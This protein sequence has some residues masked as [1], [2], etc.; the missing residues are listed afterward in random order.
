MLDTR[1]TYPKP[2]TI[3]DIVDRF[4]PD[5]GP[6]EC[7]YKEFHRDPELS[8]L[9]KNISETTA[10]H[11]ELLGYV[12][13]RGI[14]GYGVVG[15]LDNGPGR[16]VLLRSELD[17]LPLFEKTGLPYASVKRMTDT[18]G[19]TKPVMHACGHDMHVAT[20]LAASS[21]LFAA[22]GH[23]SGRLIVLFQ[24]NEEHGG[25]ARA[26]V[27]DGLYGQDGVPRPDVI[28]GQHIV[29]NR[30]GILEIGSGCVLAGK[31]TFR[32]VIPSTG[33]HVGGPHARVNPIIVACYIILRLQAISTTQEI[34]LNE[35][36]IV[37]CGTIRAG[38]SPNVVP[39][40]AEFTVDSRA[41]SPHV[42][43]RVVE[44]IKRIV[45]AEC[46][47]SGLE[48]KP[49]ITEIEN[50]PPLVNSPEIVQPIQEHFKAIF[51]DEKV[52]P[53]QPD[54]A[55]DDFPVLALGGVPYA[56]WMLGST[57]PDLWD[58]YAK[59][60][61]LHEIPENH[62]PSFSPAVT[63]TLGP[64]VDSVSAAALTFLTCESRGSGCTHV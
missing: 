35:T 46:D 40:S 21:L 33:G 43:D 26:M 15:L 49:D 30:A 53:I 62:S 13:R 19:E 10:R 34:E 55:S 28:L 2:T 18:D 14:G 45:K 41:Y 60:G 63:Q 58:R 57:D 61:R 3:K 50:V 17:A 47:A 44:A 27:D 16:T 54:M 11:L 8:C 64:G 59:E 24:P 39:D 52:Q 7:M 37:A 22:K 48:Q 32:V 56:C 36:A 51:G 31:R 29:N 12:V 4:R 23:W 1:G 6:Y 5:L 25:G 20:L 38:T 42:L 9:E